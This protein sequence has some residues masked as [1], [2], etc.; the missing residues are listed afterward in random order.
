MEKTYEG[1]IFFHYHGDLS[2]RFS[3]FQLLKWDKLTFSF[4]NRDIHF[5]N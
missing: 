1:R 2:L 3:V 5:Q 4:L